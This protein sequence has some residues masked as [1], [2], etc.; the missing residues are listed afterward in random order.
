MIFKITWQRESF[1][2]QKQSSP[3][4]SNISASRECFLSVKNV[5]T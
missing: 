5:L 1:E 3:A 2:Q 4:L